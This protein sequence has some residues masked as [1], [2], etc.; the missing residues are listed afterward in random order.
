MSSTD[1]RWV[2]AAGR[3]NAALIIMSSGVSTQKHTHT[4]IHTHVVCEDSLDVVIVHC[5]L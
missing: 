1:V 3:L 4:H 2:T 5:I